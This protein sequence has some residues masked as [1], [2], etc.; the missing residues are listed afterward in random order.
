MFVAFI[1]FDGQF[2]ALNDQHI[3]QFYIENR[4]RFGDKKIK[5]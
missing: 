5:N 4:S 2:Y 1:A 3:V